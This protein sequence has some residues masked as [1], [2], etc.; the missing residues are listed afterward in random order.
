MRETSTPASTSGAPL[1]SVRN[2]R[3]EIPTPRG[4]L[5]AVDDVS[6]DVAAGQTVGLVGESG[7]GKTT[8]LRAVLSLLR[9][10]A[11]VTG[12]QIRYDGRDLLT[13]PAGELR[14][15]RGGEVATIFQEPM[16]ALDPLMRVGRQIAEAVR[17][18]T[19]ASQRAA[20]A[21]AVELMRRVGIPDPRRRARAYPHELSGGMRQRVMI[22]IALAGEP[23]LILCDEPTTALDVTI[24]DQILGL[25]GDLQAEQDL[26]LLFVTH[27]LPVVSQL[28]S[29]VV[30]MY[31]GKVAEGGPVTQVL[32]EPAHP[33]TRGLLR[34]APTFDR[35][36]GVDRSQPLESIPGMP[37]DLVEPPS[38]CRFHPRCPLAVEECTAGEF[39]PMPV[40]APAAVP[41]EVPAAVAAGQDHVSACIRAETCRQGDSADADRTPV[42]TLGTQRTT[43]TREVS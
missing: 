3:V 7:C 10:P 8:T 29:E 2:L 20:Q 12:G 13:M 31:A 41:A 19:G 16:S 25:L 18:G 37:P 39:L 1:L 21:R 22:A 32:S 30:V 5:V 6:F 17:S 33:Y 26:A 43:P 23:R 24:Q 14:R 4:P 11:T 42:T 9:R 35:P 15:V 34:A 36:G 27:D 40:A 28:C 38:G